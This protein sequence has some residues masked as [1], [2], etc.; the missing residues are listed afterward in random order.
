MLTEAMRLDPESVEVRFEL[1]RAL[2]QAGRLTE[3]SSVLGIAVSPDQCRV[4][5]LRGRIA[6]RL[7]RPAK[8][9]RGSTH[10]AP[11]FN[12]SSEPAL[13]GEGIFH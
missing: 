10:S 8:R 5:N 12:Q 1:G 4:H 11:V 13:S 2:Y 9:R 6:T 7:D 3:A